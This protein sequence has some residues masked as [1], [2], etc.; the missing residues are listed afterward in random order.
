MQQI[1]MASKIVKNAWN[2]K[3]IIMVFSAIFIFAACS[4][5]AVATDLPVEPSTET[6]TPLSTPT[7]AATLDPLVN[8][9][10]YS[11]DFSSFESGWEAPDDDEVKFFYKDE[12]Y[13]I[14]AASSEQYYIITS[15]KS[16]RDAVLTVDVQH[17]TGDDSLTAGL[18]FWRYEDNNNFYALVLFDN[19]TYSIHRYLDGAYGQIKLLTA[20]PALKPAGESNK[21]TIAFHNDKSDLYFNDQFV[22]RFI[23]SS[24]WKGEVGMG[25]YPDPTSDVQVAFDNLAVY[26]YDPANEFTP[27]IPEMTPTPSY[28]PITWEELVQFLSDDHTNWNDYD[29]ETYNCLD[30][31]VDVVANAHQ[32]NI[33]ARVVAVTFV[34]QEMGHAFVEF[35]TSDR[36]ITFVEPQGD[37][38]YSNV[39]IGV[40]LCDDWGKF[41]CMGVV[42]SIK[43][44]GECDHTYNYTVE[45]P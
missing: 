28:H 5:Q 9:R 33:K 29:L 13:H 37:N 39:E 3:Q 17:L 32:Q 44:Y 41:E 8:T 12:Q 34:G 38:T 18:V 35:E 21:V 25:A 10:L 23:D 2:K 24:L 22:F 20:S 7:K 1:N 43:Y 36:G 6:P 30:Y 11:D 26:K 4:P 27:L 45:L 16:F 40:P 42:S 31:A 15:G 14:Q 19:G